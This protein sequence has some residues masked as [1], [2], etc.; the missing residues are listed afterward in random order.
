MTR[1]RD[2]R[3]QTCL[4]F[5]LLIAGAGL[6]AS[7]V[8][9][10]LLYLSPNKVDQ[11]TQIIALFYLSPNEAD[12]T[13]QAPP[14][15]STLAPTTSSADRPAP[16]FTLIDLDGNQVSLSQFSGKPVV[17]NFWATWCMPCRI[18]MP[19]LIAAYEQEESD[20]VFLAIGVEDT[21]SAVRRF[22]EEYSMPFTILLDDGQVARDYRVRGIPVTFF[23]GRDGQIVV[24]YEGGMTPWS[25]EEGLRRIR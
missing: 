12:R 3:F 25:I 7:M 13:A 6:V 22:A 23:I 11:T 17:I 4:L 9:I 2:E 16:D 24:R 21:E 15:T 14:A 5:S 8:I 20:I 19:H 18:E 10:A 1:N